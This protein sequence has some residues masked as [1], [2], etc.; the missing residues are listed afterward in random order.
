[1]N[2]Q[3][4]KSD[5][6]ETSSSDE[7][8]PGKKSGTLGCVLMLAIAALLVLGYVFRD[9]PG[10]LRYPRGSEV[11]IHIPPGASPDFRRLQ[12]TLLKDV[13]DR[14]GLGENNPL[15]SVARL[16]PHGS[17]FP[18]GVEVTWPLGKG[19]DKEGYN[20]LHIVHFN[21]ELQKWQ[22]TGIYAVVSEDRK[23]ATGRVFHFSETGLTRW[24]LDQEPVALSR[25]KTLL[26]PESLSLP[27]D[28]REVTPATGDSWQAGAKAIVPRHT[29]E[30]TRGFVTSVER[31]EVEFRGEKHERLVPTTKKLSFAWSDQ[32][33][34]VHLPFHFENSGQWTRVTADITYSGFD[35]PSDGAGK[36][37]L[38]IDLIK[39]WGVARLD[40]GDVPEEIKIH[41][42]ILAG[43]D[44]FRDD[45]KYTGVRVAQDLPVLIFEN[46]YF[47]DIPRRNDD[48]GPYQGRKDPV[49]IFFPPDAP[50]GWYSLWFELPSSGVW[51]TA[52]YAQDT[53]YERPV[54]PANQYPEEMR[55]G[56][57]ATFFEI[58]S[59][60][61][62]G[63]S[64]FQVVMGYEEKDPHQTID[65]ALWERLADAET[66]LLYKR[67]GWA[68]DRIV[69]KKADTG[70]WGSYSG[71][72]DE[73]RLTG[74]WPAYSDSKA[75][76]LDGSI[77]V[78]NRAVTFSFNETYH[79]QKDTNGRIY[80]PGNM[81][82][83][84][85]AWMTSRGLRMVR[86]EFQ[87]T[88][89]IEFPAVI[90]DRSAAK[91]LVTGDLR[92]NGPEFG[93]I[94]D[95]RRI[96][97]DLITNTPTLHINEFYED[98][99]RLP[100]QLIFDHDPDN[101]EY[102]VE[103]NGEHV[104]D[105]WP[106]DALEQEYEFGKR[107]GFI[108]YLCGE[109]GDDADPLAEQE[110]FM[111]EPLGYKYW[112]VAGALYRRLSDITP[113][114][115][116]EAGEINVPGTGGPAVAVDDGFLEWYTEKMVP[117]SKDALK[118]YR[119][120][121]KS[122]NGWGKTL[123]RLQKRQAILLGA[124][125]EHRIPYPGDQYIVQGG[126]MKKISRPDSHVKLAKE[127]RRKL[128][129]EL[130]EASAVIKHIRKLVPTLVDQAEKAT[131]KIL[132]TIAE[133]EEASEK[134]GNFHRELKRWRE[135]WEKMDTLAAPMIYLNTG[136]LA[137]WKAKREELSLGILSPEIRLALASLYD[138]DH[139]PV[140]ALF[141][142]RTVA[143]IAW[144]GSPEYELAMRNVAR[145]ELKMIESLAV[146]TGTQIKQAR[147]VFVQYLADQGMS[148]ED[149]YGFDASLENLYVTL[150]AGVAR[151]WDNATVPFVGNPENTTAMA[152]QQLSSAIQDYGT[153]LYMGL[154][155]IV[156][157]L[158][159]DITLEEIA[160]DASSQNLANWLRLRKLNDTPY[161]TEEYRHLGTCVQMALKLPEL[162]ALVTESPRLYELAVK[163]S[164]IDFS[165][166]IDTY[167]EVKNNRLAYT[168][169][170]FSA[171]NT[172]MILLPFSV[173]SIGGRLATGFWGL[174]SARVMRA[175]EA[176]GLE[177]R[178]GQE[179]VASLVG[180]G[181]VF[182]T[183][184]RIPGAGPH[185]GKALS[186]AYV[187]LEKSYK[188]RTDGPPEWKVFWAGARVI[189]DLYYLHHMMEY[190]H[191]V[192]GPRVATCVEALLFT[193]FDPNVCRNLIHH[194]KVPPKTINA[195]LAKYDAEVN[196]FASEAAQTNR[197]LTK[198]DEALAAEDLARNKLRLEFLNNYSNNVK[199]SPLLETF[200]PGSDA[201]IDQQ[202]AMFKAI[203]AFKH[204]TRGQDAR[205]A[206]YYT[207]KLG[208]K[209][210]HEIEHMK[211]NVKKLEEADLF[212]PVRKPVPPE[213]Q[214]TPEAPE[215]Q[216]SPVPETRPTPVP[217]TRPT[218]VPE[219]RP[220]PVP[221]TQSAP[222]PSIP[223][224]Q[225]EKG[226]RRQT[227]VEAP[228]EPVTTESIVEARG[229]AVEPEEMDKYLE[230]K[231]DEVAPRPGSAIELE[232]KAGVQVLEANTAET[233]AAAV[234]K[235]DLAIMKI[236]DMSE[237]MQAELADE[238][239]R[240]R[241]R[242]AFAAEL[243]EAL[244]KRPA[245]IPSPQTAIE[246]S[247]M[248]RIFAV[249]D[250]TMKKNELGGLGSKS[251]GK[252]KAGG[253]EC[254]AKR[255]GV[256][257]ANP[258]YEMHV[259]DD[260]YVVKIMSWG[261][262]A[263]YPSR[264]GLEMGIEAELIHGSPVM[265]DI[266]GYRAPTATARYYPAKDGRKEY[267]VLVTRW[268]DDSRMASDLTYA[269]VIA[270]KEQFAAHKN[271]RWLIGDHDGRLDNYMEMHGM[272]MGIDAGVGKARHGAFFDADI[273]SDPAKLRRG[274]EGRISSCQNYNY[275]MAMQDRNYVLQNRGSTDPDIIK[276][277]KQKEYQ[278]KQYQLEEAFI[279]DDFMPALDRTEDAFKNAD[280]AKRVG[281][282]LDAIYNH[283][284]QDADKAR[285]FSEDAYNSMKANSELM[286][287]ETKAMNQ[288]N[289]YQGSQNKAPAGGGG[290]IR[291][292]RYK[293]AC[294]Q[295]V[296]G[297][298]LERAA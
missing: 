101:K 123:A 222:K 191:R 198:L 234:K 264:E 205:M 157:L 41:S 208:E 218:P 33:V 144:P 113:N 74:S 272:L 118:E 116:E 281:D 97:W 24:P 44:F 131:K 219:T 11:T 293:H 238:L 52:G 106:G 244:K 109:L 171:K 31:V 246:G 15:I 225:L 224:S 245:H 147:D 276:M 179:I 7:K 9:Q 63:I 200:L 275:V 83:L 215:T 98:I 77:A 20:N 153:H 158:K 166:G 235:Y 140:E 1:M 291:M 197:V 243:A 12:A 209:V 122:A 4:S 175:A 221:E 252:F 29:E 36:Q 297:E 229:R 39:D 103:H 173:G 69:T 133:Q 117:R 145:L 274:R 174:R 151:A 50:S 220:T 87:H 102:F 40:G 237:A 231:L 239:M 82:E 136:E 247:E 261:D 192:A 47:R 51:Y 93:G 165:T 256:E 193:A 8:Q 60:K 143:R 32:P 79:R 295:P 38:F 48:I 292:F 149:N 265:Q 288:R 259:G 216:L 203:D 206:A 162:A 223:K 190:T 269:E 28:F 248:D 217:E 227:H 257:S 212:T 230:M 94:E 107:E 241:V 286:R 119:T 73:Y 294:N 3:T 279:Y 278:L 16:E 260:K 35:P 250:D 126:Q 37:E 17:T 72:S 22:W 112:G 228:P 137:L 19:L 18:E 176:A 66:D 273:L 56:I 99:P 152:K 194:S 141:E 58:R 96:T 55:G 134:A 236:E 89:R 188:F 139:S 95:M 182:E 290:V 255:V 34:A 91:V 78:E 263:L 249:L 267:Y 195:V 150:T 280:K 114:A 202:F 296:V 258:V 26:I 21:E 81:D 124:L 45:P 210:G 142:Y 164:K 128:T 14:P 120:A 284:Y 121:M 2:D 161:G 172:A 240:I 287:H 6:T 242:R 27:D 266:F 138:N 187:H 65:L 46:L 70:S 178:T 169:D 213:T 86:D 233:A 23:T 189:S 199:R 75:R 10:K 154:Q 204:A 148:E 283:L 156:A 49:Q 184:Q 61:G 177:I 181:K 76:V 251:Y 211:W 84:D 42:S 185:I 226:M 268:L 207:R 285:S 127:T 111:L 5:A 186:R 232:Y 132:D 80:H 262:D 108:P 270:L 129:E 71:D 115:E 54:E 167:L 100:Q 110:S 298:N 159:R 180:W 160:H 170:L 68:F 196:R 201:L 57:R 155:T 62:L 53:W 92:E 271:F 253:H 130:K 105:F 183:V 125:E 13:S 30:L 25:P 104:A 168:F 282:E 214:P 90:L 277:V 88:C 146:K 59:E 43:M 163:G 135:E 85:N 254:Q 289:N 64:D 67:N